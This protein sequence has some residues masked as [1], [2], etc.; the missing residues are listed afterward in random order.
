MAQAALSRTASEDCIEVNINEKERQEMSDSDRSGSNT[1]TSQSSDVDLN[2]SV[3][4][5][6]SAEIRMYKLEGR[7]RTVLADCAVLI[8]LI[9]RVLRAAKSQGGQLTGLKTSAYVKRLSEACI[10]MQG[11]AESLHKV[12]VPCDDLTVWTSP[13]LSMDRRIETYEGFFKQLDQYVDK[14]KNTK[15]GE[16]FTLF[17]S[18]GNLSTMELMHQAITNVLPTLPDSLAVRKLKLHKMEINKLNF[19]TNQPAR[20]AEPAQQAGRAPEDLRRE[21]EIMQVLHNL[22]EDVRSLYDWLYSHP[23]LSKEEVRRIVGDEV[24]GLRQR[25]ERMRTDQREQRKTAPRSQGHRRQADR[26]T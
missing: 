15:A 6:H 26:P 16:I 13:R 3:P 25:L 1:P 8:P 12:G 4:G 21:E 9:N 2:D 19:G 10:Y 14:M 24:R 7:Y 5:Q 11:V 22:Q 20:R 18:L 17:I 23:P